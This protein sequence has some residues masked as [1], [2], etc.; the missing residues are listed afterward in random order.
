MVL[1]VSVALIRLVVVAGAAAVG[2]FLALALFHALTAG[3]DEWRELARGNAAVGIVLAGV[4]I[5]V[6]VI[7][8]P[9]V[10]VPLSAFD[11]GAA[12]LATALLVEGIRILLAMGVAVLAV[13]LSAALHNLLT[14]PIDE[15]REVVQGNVAVGVL[16]AGVVVGMAILISGPAA[17]LVTSLVR[18]VFR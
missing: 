2:L 6:A 11:V 4:V 18:L 13:A 17:D 5:A 14:G 8:E 3:V 9:V 7:I 1:P 12:V 16:Q 15:R 10:Q